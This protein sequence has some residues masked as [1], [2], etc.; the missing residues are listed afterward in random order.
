MA[1][2]FR[3]ADARRIRAEYS[4]GWVGEKCSCESSR[5]PVPQRRKPVCES[6]EFAA[7]KGCATYP[8]YYCCGLDAG[9]GGAGAD[10]GAISVTLRI[11]YFSSSSVEA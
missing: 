4:R 10:G 11:L 9:T 6:F 8:Y 3:I 5:S 7:L 2:P 1:A